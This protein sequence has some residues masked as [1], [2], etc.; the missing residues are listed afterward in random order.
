M[1]GRLAT[2]GGMVSRLSRALT[3]PDQGGLPIRRR[4]PSCPTT[5]LHDGRDSAPAPGPLLLPHTL[6]HAAIAVLHAI[7]QVEGR[8]GAERLVIVTL[9]AQPFPQVFLEVVKRH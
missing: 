4:M 6:R 9:L 3:A 8:H 1:W 5:P 2:C 7:I